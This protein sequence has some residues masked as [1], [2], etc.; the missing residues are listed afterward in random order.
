MLP[1][2]GPASGLL[3][4]PLLCSYL[5]AAAAAAAYESVSQSTE[6]LRAATRRRN[7]HRADN[8]CYL[9]AAVATAPAAVTSCFPSTS[10]VVVC[11]ITAGGRIVTAN[12]LLATWPFVRY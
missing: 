3:I 11:K 5:C 12:S 10:L 2:L 7:Q 6:Q 9:V 1:V 4:P 8:Y